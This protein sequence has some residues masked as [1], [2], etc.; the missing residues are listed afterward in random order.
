MDALGQRIIKDQT[1]VVALR[2]RADDLVRH[3][4]ELRREASEIERHL[5]NARRAQRA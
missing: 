3:A 2:K 4:M 1:A 5:E